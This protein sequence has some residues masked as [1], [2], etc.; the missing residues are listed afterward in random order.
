MRWTWRELIWMPASSR[1]MA[2]W[3]AERSRAWASTIF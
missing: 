3:A 2:A 1:A